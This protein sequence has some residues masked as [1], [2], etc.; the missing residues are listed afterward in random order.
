MT[1]RRALLPTIA[2]VV[3]ATAS[4]CGRADAVAS[5]TDEPLIAEPARISPA[6]PDAAVPSLPAAAASVRAATLEFV[7]TRLDAREP[8]GAPVR[9]TFIR[10]A[11]RVSLRSQS[12]RG[13]WLF[14]RNPVAPDRVSGA[15]ADHRSRVVV[16]HEDTDLLIALGLRGWADVIAFRVDPAA[17]GAM[18][19][20][21]RTT[22]IA[23]LEFDQ[24]VATT[25][26]D[27]LAEI[28]W[29][30][31]ELIA[32]DTVTR[33]GGQRTRTR[34]TTVTWEAPAEALEL[35]TRRFPAYAVRGPKDDWHAHR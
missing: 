9:E 19:R 26:G 12:E 1:N 7:R 31:D 15:F 11:R 22:R 32:G 3:A 8:G 13:E 21:G 20:T 18:R 35:L 28:W 4:A 5:F 17:L 29:N 25:E 33:L 10:T 2:I 27:G 23:G 24:F 14:V 30:A 6:A 16:E 34:L